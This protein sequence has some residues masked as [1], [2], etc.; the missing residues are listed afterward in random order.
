VDKPWRTEYT[1][2]QITVEN[3][4]SIKTCRLRT[5]N[6]RDFFGFRAVGFVTR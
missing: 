5:A 2:A 1:G 4:E 3:F 6:T